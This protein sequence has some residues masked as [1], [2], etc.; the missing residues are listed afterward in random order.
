MCEDRK[1]FE[2]EKEDVEKVRK[3]Y[4][5]ERTKIQRMREVFCKEADMMVQKK[6]ASMM[7]EMTTLA[8]RP[9]KT[10]NT[11]AS[12]NTCAHSSSCFL[13]VWACRDEHGNCSCAR[14]R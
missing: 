1:V 12:V 10:E 7:E 5:Q 8:K 3:A 14:K 9:V 4:N 2:M 13:S 6:N 11:T